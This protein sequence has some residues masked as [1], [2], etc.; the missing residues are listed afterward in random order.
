M[1]CKPPLDAS[2]ISQTRLRLAGL[3]DKSERILMGGGMRVYP[4]KLKVEGV[5]V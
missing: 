5:G 3:V 4:A 2:Q 1:S